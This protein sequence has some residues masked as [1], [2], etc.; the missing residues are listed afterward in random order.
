M[1]HNKNSVIFKILKNKHISSTDSQ[2][3]FDSLDLSAAWI[4]RGLLL[5][6]KFA[7]YISV[8]GPKN[9]HYGL[10]SEWS[11]VHGGSNTLLA[12]ESHLA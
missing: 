10:G 9:D 4:C 11:P 5:Y 1:Y 3:L 8:L 7:A 12:P 6:F 2:L